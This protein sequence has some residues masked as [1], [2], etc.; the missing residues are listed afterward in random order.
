MFAGDS[1]RRFLQNAA[2]V[3]AVA[4]LGDLAFLSRL[5]PVSAAEAQPD[6]KMVQLGPDIEPV[7]RLLE[8]TPRDKLLEVLN[9]YQ[10]FANS[11][12][13]NLILTYNLRQRVMKFSSK[14]VYVQF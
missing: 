10:A 3:G 8:D 6:A 11:F 14:N 4:G 7:V 5:K 12:A 13:R 2:A 9:F 1:R